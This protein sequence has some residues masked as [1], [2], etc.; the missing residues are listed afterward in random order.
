MNQYQS[1]FTHRA[2][3]YTD[4]QVKLLTLHPQEPP[5]EKEFV[6]QR[7][8]EHIKALFGGK[9]FDYPK[10]EYLIARI[11]EIGA[12]VVD[13]KVYIIGG[14]L[15]N[16][17]QGLEGTSII[18]AYDPQTNTWQQLADLPTQRTY[19]YTAVVNG[20]IYGFGGW[21]T[22]KVG[23]VG[24][25]KYPIVVE[26]YDPETDTWT[27]KKDM[28]VSRVHPAIGVVDEKIYII[29]G[30]TGWGKAKERWMD[31]VDIYEPA[32]DAWEEGPKMPTQRDPYLG[33]VVNKG[34]LKSGQ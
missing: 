28:P 11:I 24:Q 9:V 15:N 19:P 34:E 21:Y 16:D 27:R 32:T 10:S 31:R 17:V 29:G 14:T 26:A 33:G 12:A 30:S 22:E 13:D 23:N 3:K 8:T 1:I 7:G 20:I 6:N 4:D 18:E 2:C 25:I 5:N